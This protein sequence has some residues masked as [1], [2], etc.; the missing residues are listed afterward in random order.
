MK[1]ASKIN[2][3]NKVSNDYLHIVFWKGFSEN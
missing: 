1:V 3:T 2:D